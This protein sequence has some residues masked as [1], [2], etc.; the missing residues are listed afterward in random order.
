MESRAE[1]TMRRSAVSCAGK[2]H[3]ELSEEHNILYRTFTE[4]EEYILFLL[5]VTL[6]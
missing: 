2:E 6:A 5:E 1:L 3:Q 4:I